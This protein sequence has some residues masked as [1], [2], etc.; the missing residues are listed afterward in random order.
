[1][2]LPEVILRN[3]ML[4]SQ[5]NGVLRSR[6][7]YG[8][9]ISHL[10][11]NSQVNYNIHRSMQPVWLH[12]AN[13]LKTSF[14]KILFNITHPPMTSIPG[15]LCPSCFPTKILYKFLIYPTYTAYPTHCILLHIITLIL[16]LEELQIMKFIM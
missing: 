1:M 8:Q 7:S 16:Y 11:Y 3:Y 12:S 10:S 6:Q 15:V 13:S 5:V 14:V 4:F 9:E 2:G